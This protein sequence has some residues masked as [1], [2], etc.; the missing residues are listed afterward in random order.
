MVLKLDM[1]KAYDMWDYVEDTLKAVDLPEKLIRAIIK[2]IS[3]SSCKLLWNGESQ[4]ILN[5]K[6]IVCHLSFLCFS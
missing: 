1:E 2:I 5:I 4:I 3:G 6:V